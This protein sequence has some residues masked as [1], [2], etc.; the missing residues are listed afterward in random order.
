MG[1]NEALLD[2]HLTREDVYRM[3][4]I[5][6]SKKV[7]KQINCKSKVFSKKI[8]ASVKVFRKKRITEVKIF[9]RKQLHR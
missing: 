6:E 4:E 1:Y 7:P 8:I 9:G 3:A 2:L 5:T